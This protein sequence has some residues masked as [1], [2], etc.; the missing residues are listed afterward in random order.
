MIRHYW[1]LRIVYKVSLRDKQII[2]HELTHS[3]FTVRSRVRSDPP[4]QVM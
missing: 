1:L 4:S 2:L 3:C